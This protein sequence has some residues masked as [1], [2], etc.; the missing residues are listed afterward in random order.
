[1]IATRPRP[2]RF[3]ISPKCERSCLL[4]L[5]C[6]GTR[7]LEGPR[8]ETAD[9]HRFLIEHTKCPDHTVWIA[10]F[11]FAYWRSFGFEDVPRGLLQ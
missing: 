10:E 1:M 9:L 3:T 6:G 2:I 7:V 8:R 11:E 5:G 4:C